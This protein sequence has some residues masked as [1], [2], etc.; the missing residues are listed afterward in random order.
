MDAETAKRRD[1][2]RLPA[3]MAAIDGA[4]AFAAAFL[5]WATSTALV[6]PLGGGGEALSSTLRGTQTGAGSLAAW[7]GAGAVVV[8]VIAVVW[9]AVRGLAGALLAVAGLLGALDVAVAGPAGTYTADPTLTVTPN[10]LHW[11]AVVA[12]AAVAVAGVV[13]LVA[14]LRG[15]GGA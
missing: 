1:L 4:V 9:R 3:V 5:P 10:G 6:A 2:G 7:I 13:L 8:A 15:R 14:A 11:I 12:L